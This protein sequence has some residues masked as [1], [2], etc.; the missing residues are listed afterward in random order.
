MRF[1][2]GGRDQGPVAALL[3][4]A[5]A[6]PASA[7]LALSTHF[8]GDQSAVAGLGGET[9]AGFDT[10]TAGT[11]RTAGTTIGNLRFAAF[12]LGCAE[13]QVVARSGQFDRQRPSPTSAI[14]PARGR[15]C[16][17][18]EPRRRSKSLIGSR[19]HSRKPL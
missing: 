1:S 18:F 5:L 6:N 4:L 14:Q 19:C 2:A 12:D 9:V 11:P 7:A 13:L 17:G 3:A 16:P 10:T 8:A 15:F